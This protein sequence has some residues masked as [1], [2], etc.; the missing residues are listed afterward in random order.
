[1]NGT[2]IAIK[3]EHSVKTCVPSAL[4]CRNGKPANWTSAP[5]A[6]PMFAFLKFLFLFS[7]KMFP[8]DIECQCR[9][10]GHSADI[11]A[12]ERFF[13]RLGKGTVQHDPRKAAEKTAYDSARAN[14][15]SERFQ[16]RR[17]PTHT[18]E[19]IRHSKD[20]GRRERTRV[21]GMR[22]KARGRL[23]RVRAGEDRGAVLRTSDPSGRS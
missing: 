22:Q 23:R 17:G 14:R 13:L 1:M 12:S 16:D 11:A 8:Q 4:S 20:P 2:T 21:R 5:Q 7:D 6:M 10:T 9:Q 15:S 19:G 3:N 18:C